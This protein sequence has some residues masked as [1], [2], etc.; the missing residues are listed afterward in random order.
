ME[1]NNTETEWSNWCVDANISHFNFTC[2]TFMMTRYS[3]VTQLVLKPARSNP[4]E[5]WEA[6]A[7]VDYFLS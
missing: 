1:N 5:F 7:N 6:L 2:D 3:L 4:S